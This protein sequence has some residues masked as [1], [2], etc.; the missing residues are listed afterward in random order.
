MSLI[1]DALKKADKNRL[2]EDGGQPT[3]APANATSRRSGGPAPGFNLMRWAVAA[4]LLSCA[5]GAAIGFM[6]VVIGGDEPQPPPP[7]E[8]AVRYQPTSSS[9]SEVIYQE[10]PARPAE[11][12]VQAPHVL[13]MAQTSPIISFPATDAVTEPDA[14]PSPPAAPGEILAETIPES[15]SPSADEPDNAAG[16]GTP[17]TT[18][19]AAAAPQPI[20][21]EPE[22][23]V[24]VA[25]PET[26]ADAAARTESADP[27]QSPRGN[28]AIIGF[29]EDS[30]V[31]GVKAAGRQSR[32]LMNNRVYRIDSII[33]E[34]TGLRIT[35]IQDNYINLVDE[36]GIQYRKTF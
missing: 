12:L 17:A 23:P 15:L 8:V 30:R 2:R 24:R 3:A 18:T 28:P 11:P 20:R 34:E 32:V 21:P 29:L 9:G 33:H 4:V 10:E 6:L 35:E 5:L 13:A 7:R 36:S 19:A 14:V 31:T 16:S 26:V 27:A 1:N 25:P 22:Q